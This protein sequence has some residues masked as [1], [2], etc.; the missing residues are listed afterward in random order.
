MEIGGGDVNYL[1]NDI[2]IQENN[3]QSSN[4]FSDPKSKKPIRVEVGLKTRSKAKR[5]EIEAKL[6]TYLIGQL[7]SPYGETVITNFDDQFLR[8]NVFQMNIIGCVADNCKFNQS[9]L[10]NVEFCIYQ[11]HDQENFTEELEDNVSAADI[12]ILPSTRLHGQ[13]EHLYYEENIKENL[14]EYAKTAMLFS[15]RKINPNIVNWN[16]LILLHGP[17]GT[18]KTS[19]CRALAHKLTILLSGRYKCGQLLEINSHSLF[20]KWFSESGKLVL[21]MFQKIQEII[22][23]DDVLVCV[24]IDEVE[25]LTGSRQMMSINEPSDSIR[26]VNA[27][28]TQLDLIKRHPNVLILTTSNM[29]KV[30]DSAFLDRVDVKQYVGL[31]SKFGIYEIYFNCI[32]ELM[33]KGIIEREPDILLNQSALLYLISSN[34]FDQLTN[35]KSYELLLIAQAS[36]GLSGRTLRKLP[37]IAHALFIQTSTC[38]LSHYLEALKKAVERHFKENPHENHN[39]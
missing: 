9:H 1:K 5:C 27:L 28:L 13:W 2:L 37:F 3:F 30:I 36:D 11:L 20:S 29:S 18:G 10:A 34:S 23:N 39:K 22:N 33:E 35:Q 16:R 4:I 21:K 8:Q 14:L 7:V 24:L 26:V 19:L 17:P 31:P 38:G 32:Q 25:S 12:C 6:R 15:D